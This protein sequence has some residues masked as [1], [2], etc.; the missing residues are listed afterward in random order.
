MDFF[1][2]FDSR[3]EIKSLVRLILTTKT[4][5]FGVNKFLLMEKVYRK[6]FFHPLNLSKMIDLNR[7][8]LFLN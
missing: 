3:K 4:C 5:G 8:K 1:F 6:C 7:K 2:I